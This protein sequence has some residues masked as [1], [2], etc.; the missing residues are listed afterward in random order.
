MPVSVRW[1][2]DEKTIARWEFAGSWT[3]DDYYATLE[4]SNQMLESVNHK[5][6]LLIIT[7]DT[8]I[9][10]SGL[11]AQFKQIS[12]FHSNVGIAVIVV[13][14]AFI[15]TMLKILIRYQPQIGKYIFL[16]RSQDKAREILNKQAQGSV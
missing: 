9:V 15:E 12:R 13:T 6:N 11:T 5:V 10:P 7:I 16:T 1:E 8:A 14:S 4:Q 2:D 3:W